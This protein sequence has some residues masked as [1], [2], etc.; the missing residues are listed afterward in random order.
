MTGKQLGSLPGLQ[1]G[2]S[3]EM[4]MM[5]N[6]TVKSL[7]ITETVDEGVLHALDLN[8]DWN[9]LQATASETPSVL[10][11]SVREMLC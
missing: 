10:W 6:F 1:K 7:F 5:R 11:G 8:L 9:E 4:T 2:P 3:R